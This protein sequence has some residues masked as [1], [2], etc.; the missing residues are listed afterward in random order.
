MGVV[1]I[2]SIFYGEP[3]RKGE[4]SFR[5]VERRELTGST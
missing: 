5:N 4:F 2:D 1:E 3:I